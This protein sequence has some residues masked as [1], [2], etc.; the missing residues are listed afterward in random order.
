MH[1]VMRLDDAVADIRSH[2]EAHWAGAGVEPAGTVVV[3]II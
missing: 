2:V 1:A 3:G